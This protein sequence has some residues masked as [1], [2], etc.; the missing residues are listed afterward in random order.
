MK[1]LL[2]SALLLAALTTTAAA[3]SPDTVYIKQAQRPILLDREDNILFY[4]KVDSDSDETFESVTLNLGEEVNLKNIKSLKLYYSGSESIY[5]IPEGRFAPIEYISAFAPNN[6]RK[7]NQSYSRLMTELKPKS[8]SIKFEST[9]ELLPGTNYFWISVEMKKSTSTLAKITGEIVDVKIDKQ[10]AP[11]NTVSPKGVESRMGVGVRQAGDDNSNAFRIPGLA[12]TNQGTLL[13]VYDVRYNNSKDLQEHVDIGLSRSTNG[14]QSWEKMRLPLHFGEYGGVP[15][16][17]NGVGDPAILVD[18]ETNTIWVIAIWS[19]GLGNGASWYNSQQGNHYKATSQLVLSKSID[20]GKS[21][22]EP[23]NITEQVKDPSWRLLLQGPG[24]G[25]TMSDGTLVFPIQYK[26]AEEM[27]HAGIMYSKDRGETWVITNPARSNTTEAQVAELSDGSLMLNMR[28]N[29]GG[30][31]AVMTTTDLGESWVDHCSSRSAL[32]EPVCQASLISVKA[33]DNIFGKDI[34]IF[35]NPDV[36]K[37]PR[38]N[39]TIKISFDD[40][41]TWEEESKVLLDESDNWGYSCLTMI[42]KESVGILYESSVAQM[43]FQAVKL[44]D[45]AK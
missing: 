16:A 11:L 3:A 4:M 26:D 35:S 37:S 12:T 43:T 17:Q 39:I 28:D 44:R 34:L 20:D 24:R 31:R 30:S 5:K 13:G 9:Q 6:T 33:E 32:R 42:D 21:W 45:L 23:I 15:L 36:D 22:S 1:R 27:P 38:R 25:I 29:R 7:A 14:G 2:Y 10:S 40:G 8:N 18:T 19:H 41:K